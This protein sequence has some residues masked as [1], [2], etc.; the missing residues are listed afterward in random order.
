[1][2]FRDFVTAH[3]SCKLDP[4]V[5]HTCEDKVEFH[6]HPPFPLPPPPAPSKHLKR[7]LSGDRKWQP[8]FK[9]Q[10]YPISENSK[11]H[12]QVC[13][14]FFFFCFFFLTNNFVCCLQQWYVQ[15]YT[16]ASIMSNLHWSLMANLALK[17][18]STFSLI[19]HVPAKSDKES[20]T[21]I[22]AG[23]D[24]RSVQKRRHIEIISLMTN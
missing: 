16:R 18:S 17:N 24:P 23:K 14:A 15:Q 12:Y 21:C 2:D 9:G 11:K 4:K 7:V 20:F 1:M 19:S 10:G 3:F 22:I 5:Y 13:M 6:F 8:C